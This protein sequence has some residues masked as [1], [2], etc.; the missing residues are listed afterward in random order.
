MRKQIVETT[1]EQSL[2]EVNVVVQRQK[3]EI[4]LWGGADDLV[5]FGSEYC[6]GCLAVEGLDGITEEPMG[7]GLM[8]IRCQPRK[9]VANE[10]CAGY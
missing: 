8:R 3:R 1:F 9:P 2:D 4:I 6:S 5:R 10:H 7:V